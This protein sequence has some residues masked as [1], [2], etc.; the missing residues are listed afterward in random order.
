MNFNNDEIKKIAT[1]FVHSSIKDEIPNGYCFS[2]CFPLS[3]LLSILKIKNKV[4]VGNAFINKMNVSHFWIKF[5]ADDMILDPTI[6][7]FDTSKDLIY[8]GKISE[9]EITKQ[10][11]ELNNIG[12]Q[13]FHEIYENWSAPLYE[14][15]DRILRSKNFEDKM[16]LTN[17]K[18]ASSFIAGIREYG[19]EDQILHNEFA[20]LYLKSI[21]YNLRCRLKDGIQNSSYDLNE[22]FYNDLVDIISTFN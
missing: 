13:E 4:A 15:E 3:I 19:L 9:D 22:K 7:Q 16:N 17:I 10:Y 5:E 12:E 1:T 2:I 14:K 8:L 18:I 21:E 11:V 20:K 6:R